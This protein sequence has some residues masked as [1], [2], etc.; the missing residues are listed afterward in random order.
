[1]KQ[2][3]EDKMQREIKFR[4]WDGEKFR[5]SFVIHQANGLPMIETTTPLGSRY[6]ETQAEWTVQQYTGLIDKNGQEIYEG[7]YIHRADGY[8]GLVEY[9]RVLHSNTGLAYIGF[10]LRKNKDNYTHI[11]GTLEVIGN[12][13]E[14]FDK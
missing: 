13:F 8:V 9:G 12:I 2:S 11:D 4:A 3:Y 6:L 14:G 7:D 1:L 10:Y 5:E